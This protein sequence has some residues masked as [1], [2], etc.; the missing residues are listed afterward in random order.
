MHGEISLLQGHS[1]AKISMK[2][3]DNEIL[4]LEDCI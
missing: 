2:F 3:M 1:I 4:V